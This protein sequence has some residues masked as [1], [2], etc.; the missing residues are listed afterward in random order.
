MMS[1]QEIL[2]LYKKDRRKALKKLH[3]LY[4]DVSFMVAR[5][6]LI[7][8]EDAEETVMDTFLIAFEKLQEFQW[9]HEGSVRAWLKKVT[10]NNCL[11]KLRKKRLVF[12]EQTSLEF[13]IENELV[14]SNLQYHEI[15]KAI[16]SLPQQYAIVFQLHELD[17]FSHPEIANLLGL[18]TGSSKAYLNRART[19]LKE[20]LIPLGYKYE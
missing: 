5:R 14:F 12:E 7:N 20:L 11:M 2:I 1:E 18:S 13:E 6:Y 15:I 9:S 16:Q 19:T 3:D 10:V 4:A 17:G 8:N